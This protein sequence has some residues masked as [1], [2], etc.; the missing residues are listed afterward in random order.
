MTKLLNAKQVEII[1]DTVREYGTFAIAAKNAGIT[2]TRLKQV[3]TWDLELKEQLDDA[4]ALYKDAIH[5]SVLERA[6][7]GKS[8][9]LLKMLAENQDPERY[10]VASVDVNRKKPTGL[11]L[12]DFEAGSDGKVSETVDVLMIE[13]NK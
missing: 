5:M 13:V 10:K 12:R 4:M 6:T 3:L 1:V 2:P 8:D 9:I 7:V 11:K